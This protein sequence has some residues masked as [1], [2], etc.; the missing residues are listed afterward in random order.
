MSR[1]QGSLAEHC[2]DGA[3]LSHAQ[4]GH[5]QHG[6]DTVCCYHCRVVGGIP[7]FPDKGMTS[8][9]S[10]TRHPLGTPLSEISKGLK[11]KL[12]W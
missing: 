4:Q 1:A 7:L 12:S 5:H 11:D 3:R 6:P 8:Q 10:L 2:W 9:Q